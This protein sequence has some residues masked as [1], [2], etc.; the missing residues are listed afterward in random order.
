MRLFTEQDLK[1]FETIGSQYATDNPIILV[2]LI[3]HPPFPAT[4]YITSY[5]PDTAEVNGY[6]QGKH[7]YITP[8]EFDLSELEDIETDYPN[9]PFISGVIRD[10]TFKPARLKALGLEPPSYW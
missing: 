7:K 3:A 8:T 1:R 9:R 5:D 10:N 2:K 4:W 6:V